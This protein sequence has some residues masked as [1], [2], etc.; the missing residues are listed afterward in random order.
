MAEGLICPAQACISFLTVNPLT[1][2]ATL[3]VTG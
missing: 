1:V 2:P 3:L